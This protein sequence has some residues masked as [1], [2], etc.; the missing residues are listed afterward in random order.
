MNQMADHYSEDALA[1]KYDLKLLKRILPFIGK[2]RFF[3]FTAILMITMITILELSLPYITK[4]AIDRYIVPGKTSFI[5]KNNQKN[6]D[7]TERIFHG[8]SDQDGVMRIAEKYPDLFMVD[9]ESVNIPFRKLGMLSGDDLAILRKKDIDGMTI[10][11]GILLGIVILNFFLNFIQTVLMEYTGQMIMHDLRMSLY[12]HMQHL[13]M[14]YYTKN[15]VGRLVT[16]TTNDIQNLHEMFTS[17]I[18]FVFK[19]LFLLIGITTVLFSINAELAVISF[20]ALPVVLFT[21]YKFADIARDIFRVLRIKLAEINTRFSETIHGMQVLQLFLKEK[22]NY[23]RFKQL[24]RDNYL[25]G[26]QQV[27][28]FAIFMPIIEL[29]GSVTIALVIFYGGGHVVSKAITLGALVAFISYMKLFF[30]PIRDIA[31]KFNILQNALASAERIFQIFDNKNHIPE[32]IP[33]ERHPMPE[34]IKELSF[35]DVSFS[36]FPGEPVLKHISFKVKKGETI[37]IVGPTGT[38]KTSLINLVIRLYDP[39]KGAILINDLDIQSFP[40]KDLRK[41]ISLVSQDPF[42]FSGSLREN[43]ASDQTLSSEEYDKIL[44]VSNCASLVQKLPKGLDTPLSEGGTSIS[45]GER[46]LIS[47]ARAISRNP[48]LI[49]FDEA[50]SYIDSGSEELVQN[51]ISRLMKD[52]TAIIIAHRLATAKKADKIYVLKDGRFIESGPHDDL[53]RKKGF[54][55]KLSQMTSWTDST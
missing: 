31:E 53:M 9:D 17:I 18:T 4:I 43:I 26:M 40:V 29:M 38:G 15:P 45:S 55:Y 46:Q 3:F 35:N 13:S 7:E 47:I 28:L 1:K 14:S 25:A 34:V 8:R 39:Q 5:F 54:Y 41:K 22:D 19:D 12:Q 32:P 6:K 24:N 2:Y 27:R 11:A 48:D 30:R 44:E 20:L 52:R 33:D 50:T 23:M 42:L 10:M 36:Y 49:I 21:A 37:A 51:A 16:R